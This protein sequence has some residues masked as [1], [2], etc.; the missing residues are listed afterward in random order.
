VSAGAR[1]VGWQQR[2]FHRFRAHYKDVR[3]HEA[4]QLKTRGSLLV[5][6]AHPTLGDVDAFVMYQRL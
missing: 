2:A 1:Y 4:L 6:S 5:R 3:P